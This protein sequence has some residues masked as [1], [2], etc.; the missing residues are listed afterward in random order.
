[1]PYGFK[2]FLFS[3]VDVPHENLPDVLDLDFAMLVFRII[4]SWNTT[5][6][7]IMLKEALEYRLGITREQD[8]LPDLNAVA[9]EAAKQGKTWNQLFA[10]PERDG[11]MYRE[12][13]VNPKT[14]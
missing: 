3:W 4:E 10:I 12:N 6:G 1:M 5:A 11:I 2:N 8:P 13:G 7:Q 14:G 9:A